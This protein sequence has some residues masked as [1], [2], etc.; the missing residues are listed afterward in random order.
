MEPKVA[1]W[2]RHSFVVSESTAGQEKLKTAAQE[3]MRHAA[4]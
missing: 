4:N 1:S 2:Y 3:G